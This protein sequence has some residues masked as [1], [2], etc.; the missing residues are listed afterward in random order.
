MIESWSEG[1][2]YQSMFCN[3][4]QSAPADLPRE[5]GGVGQG[6]G[7]HELLEAALATCMTISVKMHAAKRGW[8]VDDVCS[9]VRIDR[10]TPGEARFNYSLKFAGPLSPDQI[11][12]LR[13]AAANCPVG[14]TLTGK[15]SLEPVPPPS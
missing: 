11:Q 7:P 9:E 15:I 14:R 2:S 4:V 1:A 12:E 6:F 13:E 5:K 3:G 10:S 8:Q